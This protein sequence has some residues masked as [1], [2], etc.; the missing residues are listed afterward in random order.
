MKGPNST[1]PRAQRVMLI[2]AGLTCA[3]VSPVLAQKAT[4]ERPPGVTDSAIAVGRAL[5]HGTAN[6]AGCHGVEG[7]GS[8]AAPALTDAVWLHGDGSY[9]MISKLVLHGVTRYESTEGKPM[10]MRGWAPISDD[11]VRA[12]AAYVWSIGPKG[13]GT[14]LEN[15]RKN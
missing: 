10:P 8:E 15:R 6:C 9:E 5:F 12:V 4:R 14:A 2:A 3:T 1:W 7:Q 11:Q 13:R